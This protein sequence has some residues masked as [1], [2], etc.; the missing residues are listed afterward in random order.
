MSNDNIKKDKNKESIGQVFIQFI[1]FGLV[2]VS[3]TI[4][5]GVIYFILNTLILPG[6]WI[7]ASVVSWVISVLWAYLMQN[8]FVFKEDETKEKRV[9]WKALIKT[10][11]T[12][13]FTGLFLNNVMLFLW[14]N[15]IDIAKYCGPVITFFASIH[16]GFLGDPA[17]FSSNAG[18]FINMIVSI[19][20]NFLINKFWAY[21]QEEKKEEKKED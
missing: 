6:V 14:T 21:R 4:I 16:I 20:L 8:I 9:W 18:W 1:K 7:V 17:T 3:N 11:M 12:Y 19:P 2:G 5:S 10:Y 13:A 15:V